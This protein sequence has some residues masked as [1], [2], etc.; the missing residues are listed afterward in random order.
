MENKSFILAGLGN[1]GPMYDNTRHN[2]G[3]RVIDELARRWNVGIEREKWNSL[4]SRGQLFGQTIFFLK[5]ITFMNLSG[6]GVVEFANFY[7]IDSNHIMIIH[8]DLDMA[9]GRIKLVK[10]GGA[11]GHNGIKSLVE[12][13]GNREFY[14]LKVGIGRPGQGEVHSGFPIEKYVLGTIGDHDLSVLDSRFDTI[15]EGVRQFFE[16]GPAKA[17]S[18]LNSLK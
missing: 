8:D 13:L 15:E 14:R 10:G 6:R 11:G 2:I 16:D 1:K 5:P 18:I 12:H 17:M 4:S 7:K 9:P 3:F